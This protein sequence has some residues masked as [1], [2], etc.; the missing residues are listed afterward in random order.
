MFLVSCGAAVVAIDAKSKDY[1]I[2]SLDFGPPGP[3][4]RV[5]Q[6]GL[7]GRVM[8]LSPV[9]FEGRRIIVSAP[10]GLT[11]VVLANAD[12]T[13]RLPYHST[14]RTACLEWL[15]M[16]RLTSELTGQDLSALLRFCPFGHRL[17]LRGSGLIEP[18]LQL[19]CRSCASD[20]LTP[21]EIWCDWCG[22][23]AC[24]PC[25]EAFVIKGRESKPTVA[26]SVD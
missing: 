3:A 13:L 22:W 23:S 15:R 21:A 9:A 11:S 10:E 24:R 16:H 14:L 2:L 4:S 7:H 18:S 1:D 17:R 6:R 12:L 8:G 5:L 20:Q 25:A 19:T 26:A